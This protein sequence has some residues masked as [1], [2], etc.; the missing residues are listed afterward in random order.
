MSD[1]EVLILLATACLVTGKFVNARKQHRYYKQVKALE[2]ENCILKM[3]LKA[4]GILEEGVRDEK[5][6][7][8]LMAQYMEAMDFI[9]IV[10]QDL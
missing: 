10:G 6:H 7:D 2:Y 9:D 3:T 1:L 4:E 5:N 8:L